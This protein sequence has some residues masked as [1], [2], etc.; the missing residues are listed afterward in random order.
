MD[1]DIVTS[2]VCTGVSDH[3]GIYAFIKAKDEE[4]EKIT[5]RT[6]RNYE[7]EKL[8]E[9]FNTNLENSEF[10]AHLTAKNVNKA[11]ECWTKCFQEAIEKNAPMKTF[12][13]KD[14]KKLPWFTEELRRLIERKNSILQLW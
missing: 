12:K 9:D 7:K 3:A 4:D 5:C 11:T 2:G 13:K 8:C 10:Q 1:D 6:Y 14:R